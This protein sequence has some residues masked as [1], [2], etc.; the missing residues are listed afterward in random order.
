MSNITNLPKCLIILRPLYLSV[1]LS[2]SLL[3]SLYLRF[4]YFFCS[5][6]SLFPFLFPN[7]IYYLLSTTLTDFQYTRAFLLQKCQQHT[8]YRGGFSKVPHSPPDIL[9]SFYS[10]CWLSL[11]SS[12]RK[13][14]GREKEKEEGEENEKKENESYQDQQS[15]RCHQCDSKGQDTSANERLESSL[16]SVDWSTHTAVPRSEVSASSMEPFSV[17]IESDRKGNSIFSGL[18]SLRSIDPKFALCTTKCPVIPH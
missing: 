15:Q 16:S 7:Y 11:L 17:D 18:E 1:C 4:S 5:F 2:V 8:T 13:E 3:L 14:I 10:V 12:E 6:L 9:H